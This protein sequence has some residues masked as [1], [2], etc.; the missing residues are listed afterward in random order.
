MRYFYEVARLLVDRL[1]KCK[2]ICLERALKIFSKMKKSL[3]HKWKK[4][5]IGQ[6]CI[7]ET[8]ITGLIMLY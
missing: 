7:R 1:K 3:Y 5:A 8:L 4:K 2:K 6:N